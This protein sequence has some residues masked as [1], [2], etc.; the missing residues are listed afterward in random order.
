VPFTLSHP[1]AV[2][3]FR[4]APLPLTAVVAGSMAPDTPMFVR[5]RGAYDLTHSLLGV[6]TVDVAI[7]VFAVVF[8][9]GLIRDPLVDLCPAYVRDRLEPTVRYSRRQWQL[10]VPAV[11]LGSLTHVAWDAF[12]HI[13]RWG[14]QHISWL[15]ET[16]GGHVGY[17]WTQYG[18]SVFGLGVV[19]IWAV[20]ELRRRAPRPRPATV[21]GLGI[22]ALVVVVAITTAAGVAAAFTTAPP[23]F[24]SMLAQAAVVGT[25]I[26]VF[27]ILTVAGIWQAQTNR[28]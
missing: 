3:L 23:G 28:R 25:L 17:D 12:T 11:I 14:Y 21:P 9:F 15:R 26:M 4:G 7:S 27:C 6:F 18:S 5:V 19:A 22:R 24:G 20:V 8:W 16:H 1:A 10:V 13:N 2:W